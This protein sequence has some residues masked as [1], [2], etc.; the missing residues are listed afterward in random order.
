MD[1]IAQ[2][3]NH[4]LEIAQLLADHKG[5]NTIVIDVSNISSWTNFFVITTVRSSTHLRGL[6]D[7]LA[8]YFHQK[9][10]KSLNNFKT[11][12][13]EEW[14]LIDCG[15]FI[16]HLMTHDKREFYELEKLWFKGDQLYISQ[17]S[18]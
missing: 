8:E 18:S 9:K 14:V 5:Q 6:V 11:S 12:K 16:V 7:S 4:V 1:V 15:T 3:K 17:L 13:N 2:S 10:I